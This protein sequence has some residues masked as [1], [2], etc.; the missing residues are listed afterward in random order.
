MIEA[1]KNIDNAILL[2]INHHY[3]PFADELMIWVSNRFIWIPLYLVLVFLLYKE[4]GKGCWLVILCG[5]AAIA[6]SDQLA[7][8]IVKNMVMRYRPSH[9]L[10]LSHQLHYVGDYTG[11][12]YGFA[13]SH[14]SNT[15]ALALYLTLLMPRKRTMII[16]LFCWAGLVCYSRMYLGVHYPSDIAGGAILGALSAWLMY[17]IYKRLSGT[18]SMGGH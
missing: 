15:V 1:L 8:G 4:F 17:K 6:L 3:S 16:L 12:L 9:N 11:G 10:V 7:S 13:S 14:A 18:G 5:I 2:F